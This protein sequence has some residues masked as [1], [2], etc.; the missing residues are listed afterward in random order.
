MRLYRVLVG[1]DIYEPGGQA[2]P[3]RRWGKFVLYAVAANPLAALGVAN[4]HLRK[5]RGAELFH[6]T[7]DREVDVPPQHRAYMAS[8]GACETPRCFVLVAPEDADPI[9]ALNQAARDDEWTRSQVEMGA[10][11]VRPVDMTKEGVA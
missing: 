4:D 3:S 5:A 1:I 8:V 6:P 7:V 11:V 9:A 2:D 10:Y